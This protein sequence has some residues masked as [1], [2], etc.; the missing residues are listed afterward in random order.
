MDWTSGRIRRTWTAPANQCRANSWDLVWCD[1][2]DRFS[3][4]HPDLLYILYLLLSKEGTVVFSDH[5]K[6]VIAQTPHIQY[7]TSVIVWILL[8]L[9]LTLLG[10]AILA[11]L[12]AQRSDTSTGYDTTRVIVPRAV[13]VCRNRCQL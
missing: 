2:L 4:R 8:L 13:D 12:F 6:Q 5:Y 9:V 7:K 3:N 1:R 11:T 10:L